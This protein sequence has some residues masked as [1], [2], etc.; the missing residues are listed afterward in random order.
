MP[1]KP[2]QSSHHLRALIIDDEIDICH[3]LSMCL[4]A[5]RHEVTAVATADEALAEIAR[6]SFDL[7][8]LNLRLGTEN[9]LD[10][11]Q[12]LLATSPWLRVIVI[13]AYP[14]VETAVEAMK[15]GASEYLSKPFTPAQVR[16][17]VQKVAELQSLAQRALVLQENVS[18]LGPVMDFDTTS[19]PM[20]ESVELARQA[21]RGQATV[22]IRGETGTGKRTLARAIHAWSPRAEHPLA[23]AG[24][25]APTIAYLEAEWFGAARKMPGGN[26]AEQ[27]G[28]IAFCEGGTLLLEDVDRLAVEMQ[29]KLL[30][31]IQDR[32]Y[33][34]PGDFAI[35]RAD[36][37]IIATTSADLEA[38]VAAGMIYPDLYYALR[39][40]TIELL[41]LRRRPDDIT[42]LAARYLAFFARQTRRPIIGFDSA[43]MESLRSHSWPGNVRELRNLIERAVLVCRGDRVDT[44]D[45][46]AGLLNRVNAVALGDPVPL[47]RIEE[48]HIRGVLASA[49]SID[50]AAT[51]LGMDTVTLWRRRKQYG[52]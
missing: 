43:A 52:I 32:E 10:L 27:Q 24:C 34:R 33:E 16:L 47:D 41:P 19:A 17:A 42:L 13:T 14:A 46:P 5:E 4:Q 50:A 21:S 8:F 39:A 12:P 3:M 20:R 2:S 6:R 28:R 18:S 40:V 51:T 37:R 30:R 7:V 35:R 31:L 9:G 44:P 22:L 11:I 49:P 15:R 48:L 36:I 26:L 45:F 29:P 25:R 38:M 1:E 23:V